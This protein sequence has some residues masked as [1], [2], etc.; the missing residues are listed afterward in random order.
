MAQWHNLDNLVSDLG[1]GHIADLRA[2][3]ADIV[4]V[5][6]L[7]EGVGVLGAATRNSD[8][9]TVEEQRYVHRLSWCVDNCG[10][11]EVIAPMVLI[12]DAGR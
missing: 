3:V 8:V 11:A 12:V 4:V 6:I 9:Q 1:A 10:V 5:V 7:V 2:H